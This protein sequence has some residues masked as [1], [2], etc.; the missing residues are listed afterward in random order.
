[1]GA[2]SYLGQ[3]FR[4]RQSEVW[5]GKRAG[6]LTMIFTTTRYK[7]D[8]KRKNLAIG[9]AMF[10]FKKF[11]P[12]TNM[13]AWNFLKVIVTLILMTISETVKGMDYLM[14]GS[15][16]VLKPVISLAHTQVAYI[17][18]KVG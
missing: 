7:C 1:M 6:Y 18:N 8:S 9:F 4:P 10:V 11:I 5:V 14:V 2:R 13:C 12:N 3:V 17:P 16:L 15:N